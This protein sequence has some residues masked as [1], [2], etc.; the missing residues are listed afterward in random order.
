MQ[1]LGTKHLIMMWTSIFLS[2]YSLL[3]ASHFPVIPVYPTQTC[4]WEKLCAREK[5]TDWIC[6]L[7]CQMPWKWI[8][9]ILFLF[10]CWKCVIFTYR[11][12]LYFSSF[13]TQK[14]TQALNK[15]LR[16]GKNP[17]PFFTNTVNSNYRSVGRSSAGPFISFSCQFCSFLFMLTRDEEYIHFLRTRYK[18]LGYQFWSCVVFF[19]LKFLLK[20]WGQRRTPNQAPSQKYV[21]T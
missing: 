17:P 5:I 18:T 16:K 19:T 1:G 12:I 4:I 6:C 7:L 13:L 9:L 20:A 3:Y 11:T 21:R 14:E 8:H 15:S 2:V 10:L